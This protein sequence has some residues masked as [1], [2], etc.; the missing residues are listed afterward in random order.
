MTADD[1]RKSAHP[2][3]PNSVPSI[4]ARMLEAIGAGDIE[5][6]YTNIPEALRVKGELNLPEPMVSEHELRRHVS[7][8]LSRN[9]SCAEM[10]CFRGGGCARHYVPAVCDE[11]NRRSEFLT[12]YA[13]EP[14]EDH[15]RFQTLFEYASLMGELLDLEVVS[16]PTFD[17]NQAAS[18]SIRMAQRINGRSQILIGEHVPADRLSTITNYCR[19]AM[20]IVTVRTD[21]RTGLM[22][23]ADL[24]AKLSRDTIGVYFENP[25]YLGRIEHQGQQI[26]ERVHAAGGLCLVG[27]DPISL[28]VLAPP[29]HYGADIVCGDLQP[30][31]MHMQQGGGQA[32]FIASRDEVRFVC[33][34]PYRLFG[35]TETAVPGEWGFGDVLYDDR[36]SFGAREKGKEFVGTA[37]AL[38]G[39]TAGVYLALMGPTGMTRV[40]RTIV[41]NTRYAMKVLGAIEGV[42]VRC[43]DTSHFKEFAID[44]NAT[45]TTPADVNEALL[46]HDILGGID[47]AGQVPGSEGC[48]ILCITERHT[49]NDIDRLGSAV[50]AAVARPPAVASA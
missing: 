46:K 23:L 21:A 5:E 16:I 45:G 37:T 11:I 39:V 49:S 28:G 17:W 3:I 14:Y 35:I 43:A 12:A 32:G 19:S 20:Q 27:V 40:G 31:G 13:G 42:E 50:A 34:Y 36:T 2:Y 22:D 33:E 38:W 26:A 47:G 18:T 1:K 6:F 41:Q 8:I 24:E 44:L 30:L 48:M 7:G 29:S 9:R 10:L 25:S 4:Q 15:G